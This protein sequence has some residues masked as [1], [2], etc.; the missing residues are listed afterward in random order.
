VRRF[1]KR[2]RLLSYNLVLIA[3]ILLVQSS[4]FPKAL[5]LAVG[6]EW[7]EGI[8]RFLRINTQG[9][10]ILLVVQLYLE[11]SRKNRL[12]EYMI[13]RAESTE[14]R[15]AGL[16]EEGSEE[17]LIAYALRRKLGGSGAEI[18]SLVRVLLPD[19]PYFTETSVQFLFR[20]IPGDAEH[21]RLHY[22]L[23]FVA[24]IDEVLFAVASSPLVSESLFASIPALTEVTMLQPGQELEP[25]ARAIVQSVSVSV[26]RFTG[27][28]SG[29]LLRLPLD[30]IEPAETMRYLPPGSSLK[31]T[32][33]KLFRCGLGG[34][35]RAAKRITIKMKRDTKIAENCLPWIADRAIFLKSVTFDYSAF[36][37]R[38][39]YDFIVY[40]FFLANRDAH[41]VQRDSDHA[42][43]VQFAL[44]QWV[45]SGQGIMVT[46]QPRSAAPPGTAVQ[47]GTRMGG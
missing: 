7:S 26:P 32:E 1:T 12:E 22:T 27:D 41:E 38:D 25:A 18:E 44:N 24:A 43:Y 23:E 31:P 20:G 30:P 21:Y 46:W 10:I 37:E 4:L 35:P 17:H 15:V 45:T 9:F 11:G 47:A 36:P 42:D 8:V 14:A 40:P 19:R 16:V 33:F 29:G 6:T 3:G 28:R 34:P 39:R 13:A 2:H 5:N